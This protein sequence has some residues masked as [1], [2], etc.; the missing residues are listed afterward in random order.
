MQPSTRGCSE[1]C[2][3]LHIATNR[4]VPI[5]TWRSQGLQQIT[6]WLQS[7]LNFVS[8]LTES[9][10]PASAFDLGCNGHLPESRYGIGTQKPS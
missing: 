10:N 3:K 5:A 2:C 6:I 8:A 7:T 1:P 9:N 4:P